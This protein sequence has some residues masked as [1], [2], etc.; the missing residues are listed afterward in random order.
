MYK[1]S[2]APFIDSH[3]PKKDLTCNV[4]IRVTHL[5]K[6][7][8]YN[9]GIS[10][11]VKDY[12]RAMNGKRKTDADTKLFRQINAW[13]NK[14]TEAAECL[15]V[16]T[17]TQFEDIFLSNREAADSLSFGFDKYIQELRE[18]NRIGTAVS[19]ECAKA[20]IN[21]FKTGLKYIDITPTLLKKYENWML[22]NGSSITTVGIYLRSL[23]AIFNRATNINKTLYPFGESRGKYSIPTGRNIKKALSLNEIAKIYNYTPKPDTTESMAKDYW[24][25]LYLCNGMN[26]KDFCLLKRGNID[27]HILTFHREKTKRSKREAM[28]TVVSLK[29]EAKAIIKKWGLPSLSP[30]SYIFPHIKKGMTATEERQV[31]QQLTKTINKYMK[32]IAETLEIHKPITTYFARHSFATVLK[33]SGASVEF[34]SEALAHSSQQ[35]TKSYLSGFEQETIHKTTDVLLNFQKAQ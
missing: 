28:P 25:F 15:P 7:K 29:P 32:R 27:G 22:Q 13:L 5:R 23:R 30:D 16:F 19:Y 12:E 26:V 1:A 33:N 9:T 31:I 35:T 8:Y 11:T 2:I 4:S 24:L 14:A 34:I 17:F 6:K 21:K 18:A 3:H 10:A 20:S